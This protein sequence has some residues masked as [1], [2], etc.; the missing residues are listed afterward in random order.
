MLVLIVIAFALLA[1]GTIL[2]ARGA[3]LAGKQHAALLWLG[4]TVPLAVISCT[5]AWVLV[6]EPKLLWWVP[7]TGFGVEWQCTPNMP[8]SARVCFRH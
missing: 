4:A 1:G 5:L 2:R 7:P 8:A 6:R 3:R